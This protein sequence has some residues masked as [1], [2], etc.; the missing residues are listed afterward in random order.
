MTRKF[1][2]LAE[3]AEQ[4][5][6]SPDAVN[7]LRQQ[8]HL[9]GYRDGTSWKFKPEDVDRV[10][11]NRLSGA[12]DL[13]GEV[14]LGDSH[15][16]SEVPMDLPI[17]PDDA[18]DSGDDVV[19]LSEF[20]LGSSGPSASA[21]VIGQPGLP[22]SSFDSDVKLVSSDDAS[23]SASKTMI[24]LPGTPLSPGES[25]VKLETAGF[26][27]ASTS[28]TIIGTPGLPLGPE[29]STI[30]VQSESASPDSPSST[31]IGKPGQPVA[32]GESE[33]KLSA[34]E[35]SDF[36]LGT[37]KPPVAGSSRIIEPPP[38][39]GSTVFAGEALPADPVVD[40]G[41][42]L[43]NEYSDDDFV[44]GGP[45]SDITLSPGDSGISL[46]DPADS[47]LSLDAPIELRSAGAD[48]TFEV[49]ESGE[50]LGGATEFDSDDVMDLKTSDEF[51]LTP[52]APEGEESSEDSGSQVIAVDSESPFEAT[53]SSMFASAEGGM[54]TML[55]EDV[56]AGGALSEGGLGGPAPAFA[57]ATGPAPVMTAET[58]YP[59]WVVLLLGM[60]LLFMSLCGM[61]MYD[62]VR[63]MW[64]WS[65]P[66]PVNSTIMDAIMNLFG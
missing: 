31:V 21:T 1:V 27:D 11:E 52:M 48:P 12:A 35:D 47:G 59:I 6:M 58:P 37:I 65:G 19:L 44:L 55:E 54:S 66:L 23:A 16:I 30:R 3:A 43:A 62:L 2:T 50:D 20:E 25:A 24:G 26:D 7:E 15:E 9:Y 56:G 13:S 17:D 61:M 53:D 34:F 60:C 32:S 42:T 46:V 49:A 4:L 29:D 38:V 33:I 51:L 57:A 64:S 28:R 8:G 36:D 63:N 41:I 14:F 5:G 45:G 22:L 18:D 10:A 40:S 39:G